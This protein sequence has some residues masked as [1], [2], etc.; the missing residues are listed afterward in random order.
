MRTKLL[1]TI[2]VFLIGLIM[3]LSFVACGGPSEQQKALEEAGIAEPRRGSPEAAAKAAFELW[4]QQ[5]GMPYRNDR[6]TVLSNDGTFA[7]VRII[8]QFRETAESEWLEQQAIVE[9]RN[10]GGKWQANAWMYFELTQAE[11]ERIKARQK[12]TATAQALQ[13]QAT[14]TAEA[15]QLLSSHYQEG[16]DAYER[17]EWWDAAYHLRQVVDLDP[18]YRDASARLIEVRGRVGKIGFADDDWC[19]LR[20]VC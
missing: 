8:A 15:K 10:V 6:Y 4:A 17:A 2:R 11:Q 20:N 9:C 19:P 5:V 16:I 18:T 7:T 13:Q 1:D 14:A 3:T 12:A